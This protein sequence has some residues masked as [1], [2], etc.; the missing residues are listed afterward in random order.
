MQSPTDWRADASGAVVV[1]PRAL[2]PEAAIVE[3]GVEPFCRAVGDP[4][5][6]SRLFEQVRRVGDHLESL[7]HFQ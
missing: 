6:R 2:R 7:F 3:M 4:L 1:V 5:E